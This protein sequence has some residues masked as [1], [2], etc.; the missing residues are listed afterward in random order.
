MYKYLAS[1]VKV[2]D[3]DTLHVNV[4]CGFDVHLK[5]TIR[6]YGID[7][8]EKY[9]EEGKRAKEFT[10]QWFG[11]YGETFILSTVK[12]KK[13][14]YGRYLGTCYDL[15]QTECLNVELVELGHAR[16]YF[17]GTR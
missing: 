6:L 12:D 7:A 16:Q 2:V 1:L 8:P 10:D 13:E 15:N 3:A 5:M 9:T 14:K 4:D 17:G 11:R